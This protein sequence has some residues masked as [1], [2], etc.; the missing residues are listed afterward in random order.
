MAPFDRKRQVTTPANDQPSAKRSHSTLDF[1]NSMNPVRRTVTGV[2]IPLEQGIAFPTEEDEF[3]DAHEAQDDLAD[4]GADGAE[5]MGEGDDEAVR[6]GGHSKQSLDD[7]DAEEDDDDLF[8]STFG[9]D[10]SQAN[11]REVEEDEYDS[12]DSTG[13][14]TKLSAKVRG[15]QPATEYDIVQADHTGTCN[16]RPGES[17]PALSSQ[18]VKVDTSKSPSSFANYDKNTS[19][20]TATP[21]PPPV[22]KD[23]NPDKDLSWPLRTHKK[24]HDRAVQLIPR[25]E[26]PA[27]RYWIGVLNVDK[28]P[29]YAKEEKHFT[30]MKGNRVITVETIWNT[31]Q[32]TTMT[33]GFVLLLGGV[34][35]VDFKDKCAELDYFNDRKIIFQAVLEDDPAAKGRE[36]SEGCIP[37][38][39][40]PTKVI[41]ID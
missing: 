3:V 30:W 13:T 7:G 28:K 24:F 37:P 5:S 23:I 4:G 22:Q 15:K 29:Q 35:R 14:G 36:V 31:Y 2:L 20:S 34:E 1:D 32:M 17:T 18:G 38:A 39:S 26:L 16:G 12:D 33:D 19:R 8:K 6:L 25:L 9:I 27:H 21:A 41:E 10:A 11:R 40:D